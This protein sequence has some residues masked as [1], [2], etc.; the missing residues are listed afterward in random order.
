MLKAN[1]VLPFKNYI[2]ISKNSEIFNEDIF[3]KVYGA[4]HK[5]I[6]KRHFLYTCVML[7]EVRCFSNG[8]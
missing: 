4:V 1:V 2:H 8:P 3:V 5:V 6:K 7:Y